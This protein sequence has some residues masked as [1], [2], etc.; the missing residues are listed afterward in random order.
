MAD[1]MS[2]PKPLVLPVGGL[3]N[4][5]NDTAH[6]RRGSETNS[7]AASLGHGY[8]LSL[9]DR[10]SNL[11]LSQTSYANTPRDATSISARRPSTWEAMLDA[12]LNNVSSVPEF[13]TEDFVAMNVDTDV[14]FQEALDQ[15]DSHVTSTYDSSSNAPPTGY[16]GTSPEEPPIRP[17]PDQNHDMLSFLK[18][19]RY[20]FANQ[21]IEHAINE[22]VCDPTNH[23]FK[24]LITQADVHEDLCDLQGINWAQFGTQRGTARQFRNW[25]HEHPQVRAYA[26][27]SSASSL[28]DTERLFNFQQMN[29]NHRTFIEHYQ[30]RNL[31]VS[32]SHNDIYYVSPS[33]V[34]HTSPS[35]PYASCAMNLGDAHASSMQSSGMRITALASAENALIAGGYRGEYALQNL[36]SEY[37]TG[38]IKG[39]VSGD[40]SAIANHI[41]TFRSRITGYP[42]AV[43]CSNDSHIRILDCCTNR[44]TDH[45]RYDKIV[46]CAAT[47]PNGRLRVLVG[48]F[49]GAMIVDA[50]SGRSLRQLDGHNAHGFAATWADDDIH[51]ATAAQDCHI[52]VWDA[53]NWSLPL[54]DIACE[55]TYA[56][57][58]QF[59]PVGGGK[60]VLLAAE[61][62]DIV[63]II[64]ADTYDRKQVVNFFGDVAGMTMSS[65]GSE[66]YVANSD[67]H[68]GGLMTFKRLGYGGNDFE[69]HV[70]VSIRGG[71]GSRRHHGRS[72]QHDWLPEHD[73]EYNSRVRLSA[74]AR[75]RRG[76]GLHDVFV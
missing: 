56:T 73:L 72:E 12:G 54:A 25:Y 23:D 28:P 6:S 58:L 4:G 59:S 61:A 68:F 30:L 63:N 38:P 13:Y 60:R 16:L 65:D 10:L 49:E 26:M 67:R 50:D 35:S 21:S 52:L 40:T 5:P 24:G 42:Q 41:H 71:G 20:H 45:V 11:D 44:F 66:F 48:D 57:S 22:E 2:V 1:Y 17:H 74:K 47:S 55:G 27:P 14:P 32:T 51:V 29:T 75:R 37:G 39:R 69:E 76:L 31:L 33:K 46:N 9:Q 8:Q 7:N 64:D 43:F 18:F 19:W 34:L 3:A 70:D 15:L 62:A 53:R 36:Y